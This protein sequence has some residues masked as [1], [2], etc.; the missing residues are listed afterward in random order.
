[1]VTGGTEVA[2]NPTRSHPGSNLARAGGDLHGR[3]SRPG[4]QPPRVASW[5]V[6]MASVG[7]VPGDEAGLVADRPAL[8]PLVILWTVA[9]F[10]PI[11][12]GLQDVLHRG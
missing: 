8:L 2:P 7:H 10:A 6:T 11:F 5:C 4:Q 1:M 12:R 9:P 3:M